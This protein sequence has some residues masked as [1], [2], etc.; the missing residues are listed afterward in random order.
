[1]ADLINCLRCSFHGVQ[2]DFLCKSN[3]Q[4]LKTCG[5]CNQ[6][7]NEE[8]AQKCADQDKE[9]SE[10]S[11]WCALGK[12]KSVDGPPTLAWN[13]FIPLL[14]KNE[15]KAYELHALVVLDDEAS[16]APEQSNDRSHDLALHLAKVVWNTTGYRFKWVSATTPSC[17]N[18][19]KHEKAT[20]W[21]RKARLR[22]VS[23]LTHF[24]VHSY[25]GS[26]QRTRPQ[27]QESDRHAW[28]WNSINAVAGYL[29]RWTGVIWNWQAFIWRTI[30][31]THH[32]QI[33]RYLK[34][35]QET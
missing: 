26:R 5:P 10:K 25:K 15:D 33:Y 35:L 20:R 13:N 31:L 19:A 21:K 1:M 23:P 18:K 12:D 32:I 24:T 14:T 3:L 17:L 28:Q 29:W 4:Y 27:K 8:A 7:R 16:V 30:D 6:K 34:K 9:N 22:T 11:N 2:T